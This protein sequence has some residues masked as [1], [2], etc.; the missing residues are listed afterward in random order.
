MAS[1]ARAPDSND[2]LLKAR[3]SVG[4]RAV[5]WEIWPLF[6]SNTL[7]PLLYLMFDWWLVWLL[8]LAAS[9]VWLPFGHRMPVLPLAQLGY[10]LVRFTRWPAILGVGI[11][12]LL[13]RNIW[14]G[15][16]C[17]LT[18][19]LATLLGMA[20]PK[21]RDR[22]RRLEDRFWSQFMCGYSQLR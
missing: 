12:L 6:L 8:V 5:E 11:Y 18:P 20:F 17:F 16:A 15:I 21:N 1:Q 22:L 10:V 13:E 3:L 14:L 4:L 9:I 19:L 2:E 7:V